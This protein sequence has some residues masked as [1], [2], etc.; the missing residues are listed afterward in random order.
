VDRIDVLLSGHTHNR[1]YEAVAVDGAIVMQSGCHGSFIG[2]LDLK[3]GNGR[4]HDFCY[5]S[6][7]VDESI[8]PDPEVDAM[9]ED[10]LAPHRDMLN[11]V[12]GQTETALNRN[13]GRKAYI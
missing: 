2:R 11:T 4:V 9:V 12:V 5:E 8:E 1:V 3:V 13:S 10:A 6:I 7:N